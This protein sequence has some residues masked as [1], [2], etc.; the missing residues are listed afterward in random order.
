MD[1][2]S[3][4]HLATSTSPQPDAENI[5]K[6]RYTPKSVTNSERAS[7]VLCKNFLSLPHSARLSPRPHLTPETYLRTQRERSPAQH[8]PTVPRIAQCG[9]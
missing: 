2:L 6:V 4:A 1:R 5:A 8:L 7:A 3:L 9:H